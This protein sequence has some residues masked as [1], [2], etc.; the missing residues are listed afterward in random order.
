MA[1]G[2]RVAETELCV[3][4]KQCLDRRLATLEELQEE[5]EAWQQERNQSVAKVVWQ[6]TTEDARVK[7]KHLYPVFE[8]DEDSSI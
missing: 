6:F 3:L 5:I 7:L 8:T 2:D 4:S 1:V